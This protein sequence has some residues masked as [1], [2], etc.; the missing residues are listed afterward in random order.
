M[1]LSL[2]EGCYAG[3][4]FTHFYQSK[5]LSYVK[6]IE[7]NPKLRFFKERASQM[8][9]TEERSRLRKKRSVDVET[10]FGDIKQ[11]HGFTRFLLRGLEKVSLEFRLVAMGHNMRKLALIQ[12]AQRA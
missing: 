6:A 7:V 5:D 4:N 11:N 9:H 3:Y 10:V 8:L 12:Q 1:H 2:Y